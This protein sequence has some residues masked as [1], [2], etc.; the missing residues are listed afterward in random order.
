MYRPVRIDPAH[1]GVRPR[2]STAQKL[3]M[4]SDELAYGLM[5]CQMGPIRLR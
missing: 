5:L 4:G 3:S 2:N 1:L